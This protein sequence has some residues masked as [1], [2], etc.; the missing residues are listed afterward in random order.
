MKLKTL[1]KT[2]TATKVEIIEKRD[3]G[4]KTHFVDYLLDSTEVI[5]CFDGLVKYPCEAQLPDYL[6]NM[7]VLYTDINY[8]EKSLYIRVN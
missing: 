8:V 7:N 3:E 2:C 4:Y 5:D 6:L 1:L